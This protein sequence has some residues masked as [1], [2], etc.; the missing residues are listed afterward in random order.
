MRMRHPIRIALLTCLVTAGCAEF[1]APVGQPDEAAFAARKDKAERL[2]RDGDLAKAL[3]QWKVLETLN[4]D[5]PELARKRRAGQFVILRP[6]GDG[7][8]IPLTIADSDPD[9]GWIALIVQGVGKTT[10][11]LNSLEAGDSV[12]D[13]AGPL[14]MP[15]PIPEGRHVVVVDLAERSPGA[16]LLDRRPQAAKDVVDPEVFGVVVELI[17]VGDDRGQLRVLPVERPSHQ[18]P[19]VAVEVLP[20]QSVQEEATDQAGGAGDQG[21]ARLPALFRQAGGPDGGLHAGL[22]LDLHA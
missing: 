1:M 18:R 20:Q 11:T 13:L 2:T 6:T 5:D 3:V 22:F 15:S 10:R 21:R 9:A 7:E 4:G 14:G 12:H 19:D 17:E 16:G 8:R